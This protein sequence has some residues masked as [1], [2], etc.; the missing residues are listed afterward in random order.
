MYR[1][2]DFWQRNSCAFIRR[3]MIEKRARKCMTANESWSDY[4]QEILDITK[5]QA[6]NPFLFFEVLG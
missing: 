3:K 4:I 1:Y 2:Q 5:T 6:G